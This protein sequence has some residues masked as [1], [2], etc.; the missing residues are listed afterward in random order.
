MSRS[1]IAT[2]NIGGTTKRLRRRVSTGIVE[3]SA[4]LQSPRRISILQL[5]TVSVIGIRYTPV[6]HDGDAVDIRSAW[7]RKRR[8][9]K[10]IDVLK[11]IRFRK[12][13]QVVQ[14]ERVAWISPFTSNSV[15][16]SPSLKRHS[17]HLLW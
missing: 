1:P 11:C 15:I 4:G 9:R 14:S 8:T 10:V 7:N 12:S 13:A 3:V 17:A 6:R 5:Y 16:D 2:P